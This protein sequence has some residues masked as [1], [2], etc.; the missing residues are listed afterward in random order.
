MLISVERLLVRVRQQPS[1]ANELIAL[2]ARLR[3]E[4]AATP[5]R[6]EKAAAIR[7]RAIK[8]EAAEALSAAQPTA[9]STCATG[10]RAPRGTYVGGDC[11]SGITAD[12]FEGEH[13]AALAHA[14]TRPRDLRAPR[15]THAGCAFRGEQGCTLA[16]EHRP[17]RCVH[18]TCMTLRKELRVNGSLV[19]L[20]ETMNALKAAMH[21][22]SVLHEARRDDE[23]FGLQPT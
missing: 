2:R 9:C 4:R 21:E 12:L 3:A 5:S 11:C 6:E 18:Y 19:K 13:L 22:F 1:R 16:T 7:L 15:S 14:G 10:K 20:D 23:L 8:L 17:A